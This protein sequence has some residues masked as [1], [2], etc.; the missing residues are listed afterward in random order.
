MVNQ[1]VPVP[2]TT[3]TTTTEETPTTST[4]DPSVTTAPG[5]PSDPAPVAVEPA[6][7]AAPVRRQPTFTG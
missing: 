6:A 2:P 3:T 4:T 1:E 5:E 7:V